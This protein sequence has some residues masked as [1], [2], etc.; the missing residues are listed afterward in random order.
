MCYIS[1][2]SVYVGVIEIE[3]P[4]YFDD[5]DFWSGPNF[6]I[7]FKVK[8][9]VTVDPPSGISVRNYFGKLTIFSNL[10]NEKAW[11][12]FF[13]NALNRFPKEDGEI[14]EKDLLKKEV[15]ELY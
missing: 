14:I 5:S 9:L 4:C 7:R 15:M 13:L 12:G 11:Q 8:S 1:R 3:F 2:W 10:K 6:P